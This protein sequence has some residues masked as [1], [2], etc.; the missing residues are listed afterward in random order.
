MVG[1]R[2][3]QPKKYYSDDQIIGNWKADYTGDQP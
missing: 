1:G 3:R 2:S